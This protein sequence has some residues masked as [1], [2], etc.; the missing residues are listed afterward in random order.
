LQ[1][2]LQLTNN[3]AAA[4]PNWQLSFN[5]AGNITSI[6]NAQ[7]VSHTGNQ[8]VI[9]GASWD[10]TLSAQGTVDFGFLAGTTNPNIAPS[11]YAW[12][13]PALGGPPP[14]L[15]AASIADA[16]AS[17]GAGGGSNA[18]FAVKLSSAA[19]TPITVQYA[20]ADGTAQ[21]GRDYQATSGTLTFAPG[22]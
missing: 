17:P 9:K 22:Q 8:Y 4:V 10:S 19:T 6:W 15:P 3:N 13:A 20:T 21:A 12:T 1:A 18:T 7:I 2:D 14:P 11:N 5:Y 16:S